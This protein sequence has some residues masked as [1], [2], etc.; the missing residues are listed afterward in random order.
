MN[1]Q[2]NHSRVECDY[3]TVRLLNICFVISVCFEKS[4]SSYSMILCIS[5]FKRD[6]RHWHALYIQHNIS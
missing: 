2:I 3:I 6:P 5:G 4:V 1:E